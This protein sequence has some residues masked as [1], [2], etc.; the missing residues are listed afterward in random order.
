MFRRLHPLLDADGEIGAVSDESLSVDSSEI[1]AEQ[2]Q[3]TPVEQVT[4]EDVTKQESFAKRLKESISKERENWE[5][6]QA[7][8]YKDYE[9][10]KKTT[11]YF[12]KRHGYSDLMTMQEDIELAELQERAEKQEVSPEIQRR[13]E[14]LEAK[15]A[16]GEE[17]EKQQQEAQRVTAYFSALDEFVKDKGVDSK[18]LNQFMI[19]NELQYNPNDMTKSFNVAL[20]AMRADELEAKLQTAEKDAVKNY[21]ESKKAPRVEGSGAPGQVQQDPPK[22]FEEAAKRSRERFR[23]ARQ[24]E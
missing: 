21:L 1:A 4:T 13:L 15:A 12:Q 6:E 17:L 5:K 20:K 19:D 10:L 23:A 8:K 24:N 22:T 16:K 2:T 18:A 9:T 3:E 7:E 11:E 14:E